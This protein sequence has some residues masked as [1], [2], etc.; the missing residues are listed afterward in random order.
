[1][2]QRVPEGLTSELPLLEKGYPALSQG[3]RAIAWG[4][5]ECSGDTRISF[6]HRPSTK[7]AVIA[8]ARWEQGGVSNWG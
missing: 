4:Y 2:E 5:A 6:L 1:M 3:A 8:L 7:I